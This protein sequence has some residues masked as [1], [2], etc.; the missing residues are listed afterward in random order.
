MERSE[1][2][3]TDT[4]QECLNFKSHRIRYEVGVTK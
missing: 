4:V 2:N 1:E 3:V